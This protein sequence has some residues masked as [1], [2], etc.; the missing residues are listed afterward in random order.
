M[1][2]SLTVGSLSFLFAIVGWEPHT[3]VLLIMNYFIKKTKRD[4]WNTV[5]ISAVTLLT[6]TELQLRGYCDSRG[7]GEE[8]MSLGL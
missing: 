8:I 7:A 3:Y 4:N 2:L 5:A 6:G 1:Y